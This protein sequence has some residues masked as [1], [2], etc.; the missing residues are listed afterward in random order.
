MKRTT[1]PRKAILL[2][3]CFVV[4]TVETIQGEQSTTSSC[5]DGPLSVATEK[6]KYRWFLNDQTMVLLWDNVGQREQDGSDTAVVGAEMH[7]VLMKQLF[8]SPAKQVGKVSISLSTHDDIWRRSCPVDYILM[9]RSLCHWRGNERDTIPV[10]YMFSD[11]ALHSRRTFYGNVYLR[12]TW[13]M[14]WHFDLY[15]NCTLNISLLLIL[16]PQ[17]CKRGWNNGTMN[18]CV[19]PA[20]F[21]MVVPIA[22]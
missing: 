18:E 9:L 14:L 17:T 7:N 22:R 19:L 3:K 1:R 11:K 5:T 16:A 13:I 8:F 4:W 10:T 15:C 6:N 2:I 12:L 20:L 21:R